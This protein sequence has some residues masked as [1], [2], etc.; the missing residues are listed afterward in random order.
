[1]PMPVLHP[2]VVARVEKLVGLNAGCDGPDY[3][4]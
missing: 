3:P 2:L 4:G 1:V